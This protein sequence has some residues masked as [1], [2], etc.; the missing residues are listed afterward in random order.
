[1]DS[2]DHALMDRRLL[3]K[4]V[5]LGLCNAAVGSYVLGAAL[6]ACY[7]CENHTASLVWLIVVVMV[8][9]ELTLE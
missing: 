9:Q 4:I 3:D 5:Q 1:M 2:Y 6:I 8:L 7:I